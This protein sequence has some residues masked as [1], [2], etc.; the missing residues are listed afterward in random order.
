[1]WGLAA[2][3]VLA[4]VIGTAVALASTLS[5]PRHQLVAQ[6]HA[7]SAAQ[8]ITASTA[9]ATQPATTPGTSSSAQAPSQPG[10]PSLSTSSG[11]PAVPTGVFWTAA[12]LGSHYEQNAQRMLQRLKQSG[13]S[14]EYWYST[15]SNSVLPGSWVVTSGRFPARRTRPPGRRSSGRPGSPE[16]TPAAS[17]PSTTASQGVSSWPAPATRPGAG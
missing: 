2:A 16:P 14:G 9:P 15:T 4:V 17:V 3:G 6:S 8:A 5:A 11:P 12:V 7:A 1:M 13:F 10:Q